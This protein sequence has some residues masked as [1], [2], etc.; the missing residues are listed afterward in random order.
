MLDNLMRYLAV[1]LP[2]M[3]AAIRHS[4]ARLRSPRAYLEIQK[5]RMGS[6]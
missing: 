3:R 1:A 6:D 2:Q 5:I 4:G